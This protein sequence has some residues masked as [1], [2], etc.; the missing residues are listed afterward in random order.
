METKKYY[1]YRLKVV[2]KTWSNIILA[3]KKI[4][5][6]E[7]E[8]ASNEEKEIFLKHCATKFVFEFSYNFSNFE[9]KK[10]YFYIPTYYYFSRE[11]TEKSI[12]VDIYFY[13]ERK[14]KK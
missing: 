13:K 6:I 12:E 11:L 10:N 5:N 7:L 3:S 14:Q 4:I 9:D 1:I 8:S 2:G